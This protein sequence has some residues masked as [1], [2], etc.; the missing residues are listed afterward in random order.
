MFVL[1]DNIR[2]GVTDTIQWFNENNVDIR[3]I[4]GDNVKTVAYIAKSCKIKNSDKYID[5]S[6]VDW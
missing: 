6:T 5:L 3:V 2:N 4:S 1:R